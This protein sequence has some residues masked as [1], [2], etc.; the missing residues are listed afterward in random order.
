MI[1]RHMSRRLH[2]LH[3]KKERISQ[4]LRNVFVMFSMKLFLRKI[5]LSFLKGIFQKIS[6]YFTLSLDIL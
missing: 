2:R 1:W 5:G 3:L 6:F 4:T